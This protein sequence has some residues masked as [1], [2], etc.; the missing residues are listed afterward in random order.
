[1]SEII[2]LTNC[3][4]SFPALVEARSST[5]GGQKKFGC[6]LLI[7]PTSQDWAKI[8]QQ[9]AATAQEKWGEHANAVLGMIQPDKRLRS[10]GAG[11]E[12]INKKTFA[13]Y[14]GY[15]NMN[16]I[17]AA[18][19]NAPQAIGTDG[20]PVP[21]DNT[22]AYQ[23]IARKLYGGAYANV[24]IKFWPQDNAHGRAIRCELVAIQFN[25]DGESFGEGTPDVSSMFGAVTAPAPA[26]PNAVPWGVSPAAMPAPPANPNAMPAP[27]VNPNAAPWAQ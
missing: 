15:P 6:D 11:T 4:V 18:S 1:M 16:Y 13:P 23:A 21:S 27:L 9:V 8:M 25:K 17:S 14:D 26:N 2:M 7:D 3:R 19:A 24:A 5:E 20:R 12:K 10:F 22:M